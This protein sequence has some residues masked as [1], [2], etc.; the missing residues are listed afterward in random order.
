MI[1]V[2]SVLLIYITQI[3]C[4]LEVFVPF[5]VHLL[6]FFLCKFSLIFLIFKSFTLLDAFDTEQL[7]RAMEKLKHGQAVDIPKYDFKSYKNDV[8]P[9]RRV[10]F[11]RH[12]R[13]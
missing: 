13:I 10:N 2:H 9:A 12:R 1:I 6:T 3:S 7:L 4:T 8:F 11:F 5:L